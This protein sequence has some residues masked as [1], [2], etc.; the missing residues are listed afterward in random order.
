M[1]FLRASLSLEVFKILERRKL[2]QIEAGKIL[3]IG[4]PDVSKLMNGN[5]ER[6]SVERLIR[7]LNRLDRDVDIAIKKHSARS[8]TPAG[9]HVL[10]V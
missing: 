10:A 7:F 5:F 4:Q 3:D 9:V 6:F 1:E 2:T 8:K